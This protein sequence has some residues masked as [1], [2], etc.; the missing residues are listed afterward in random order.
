MSRHDLNAT[1]NNG[2][3]SWHWMFL[4]ILIELILRLE[5]HAHRVYAVGSEELDDIV[6]AIIHDK[7]TKLTCCW[8]RAQQEYLVAQPETVPPE[9]VEFLE[10][11]PWLTEFWHHISDPEFE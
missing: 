6:Q 1:P 9:P 11:G 5:V 4:P 10:S 8:W 2:F 3:F 7:E